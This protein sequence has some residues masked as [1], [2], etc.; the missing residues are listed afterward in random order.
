MAFYFIKD[1]TLTDIANAIREKTDT[2]D[3]LNA[4]NFAEK[5]REI[6][7]GDIVVSDDSV[8]SETVTCTIPASTYCVYAEAL[9][10]A[11]NLSPT[12]LNAYS[13]VSSVRVPIPIVGGYIVFMNI[14]ASDNRTHNLT[15]TGDLT[16][17][18]HND[19]HTIIRVTGTSGGTIT[20]T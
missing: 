3:K 9:N 17:I 20:I 8:V 1:T 10:E 4:G 5:I 11:G 13:T 19:L 2:E 7:T 15:I 6:E 14:N 12:V 18:S 16:K